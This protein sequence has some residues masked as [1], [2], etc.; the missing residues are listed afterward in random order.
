MKTYNLSELSRLAMIIALSVVLGIFVQI[1]TPTG[2]LTLLDAGIFFTAFYFGKKEGALVGGLSGF[3]IDYILGY[4]QWMLVSL[5][6]H[7]V[8]GYFAGWT[9]KWR[10]LGLLLSTISMVGAY[11]VASI[12]YYNLGEALHGLLG[13]VLQHGF[14]MLVGYLLYR[15]FKHYKIGKNKA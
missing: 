3:L 13:N 9:G 11:F 5:V 12:I 15:T 4:P 2:F 1:K 7:G 10:P 6:A 8:Q 14:G